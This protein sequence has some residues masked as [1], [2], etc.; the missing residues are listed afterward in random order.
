M[1]DRTMQEPAPQPGAFCD[2][3]CA[4]CVFA[5]TSVAASQPSVSPGSALNLGPPNEAPVVLP[6]TMFNDRPFG[7]VFVQ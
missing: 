4:E 1:Q 7:P 5:C 3:C 2:I 6:A